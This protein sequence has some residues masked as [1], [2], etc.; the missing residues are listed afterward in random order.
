MDVVKHPVVPK[1]VKRADLIAA[2]EP[3]YRLL[4]IS[5]HWVY[6][7]PPLVVAQ[8][9]ITFATPPDRMESAEFPPGTQTLPPLRHPQDDEVS[10]LMCFV[11]VK[12]E[13]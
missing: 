9:E 3:L 11:S 4:G 13:D 1:S 10:E 7:A 6:G 2:M 12:V 5:E 8:E